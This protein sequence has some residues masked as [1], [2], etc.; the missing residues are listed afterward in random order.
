MPLSCKHLRTDEHALQILLYYYTT[1]PTHA[2]TA[3]DTTYYLPTL[4]YPHAC[5]SR[6]ASTL[7][8]DGIERES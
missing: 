6:P 3:V 2:I 7:V 4:L 8:P 5:S 1:L